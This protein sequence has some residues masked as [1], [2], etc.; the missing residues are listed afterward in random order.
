MTIGDFMLYTKENGGTVNQ[1]IFSKRAIQRLAIALVLAIS[2][3]P[4]SSSPAAAISLGDYFQISYDFEFSQTV[5]HGG[6]VFYVTATGT[7]TCIKDLEFPYNMV[8]EVSI[9]SRVVA[10]NQVSGTSEILNPSYTITIKPFPTKKGDTYTI[11]KVIPLQFPEGSESGDYNVLGEL[12]EAKAK[13]LLWIDVTSYLPSSQAMGSVT[14][15]APGGEPTIA[16]SPSSFAFTAIEGGSDPPNQTLSVRNSGGGTLDWS[17]TDDMDWLTLNPTSGSSTGEQNFI[18]LS[19][20]ISGISAGSYNAAITISAPGATNTP[21]TVP[22]RLIVSPMPPAAPSNLIATP[23]STSQI[24][25]SWVDNSNNET[26]FKIE[27]KTGVGGSYNQIA[28][29]GAN[30]T[31][32][33]DSGRNQGTT[34]CYRVRAYNAGGNSA[35]SNE[36]C[37][38]TFSPPNMPSNPLPANHATGVSINADLSWSG[39]D[40]DAGD[41]VTYDVYF[42]TSAT[43]PLVSNDQPETT[44]DPGILNYNTKYYWQIVAT[45]NHG[46]STQGT[47]W[48]FTTELAPNNPPNTPSL[49]AGP[50]S[51]YT[52]TSYTYSTSATDP[53]GDQ[54]KYTFDWGDGTTS[55]TGFVN[56]GTTA[57][58]SHSWGSPGTYNVKAKATDSKGVSSG[59]SDAKAV[60]ISA[61]P[62]KPKMYISDIQMALKSSGFWFW[63]YT[64]ATATVT[65]VDTQNNTVEGAQVSG[66]WS[67]ATNDSDSGTTDPSGKVTFASNSVGS[68]PNGTTFTFTVN[69]VTKSG[70]TYNQAANIETSDSIT[71]GGTPPPTISFSPSSFS[72]NAILGGA[73]PS[74]QT[75]RIW[76]S[77]GGT[78]NW[79]VSDDAAWLSLSPTGGSSTG[80][81]DNVT[82][83][84]S[85]SGMSTG[86]YN[87]TITISAPGITNSPQTVPVRLVISAPDTTPPVINNVAVS[88]ISASSATITWKTDEMS[89]SKVEYGKTES[90]GSSKSNTSLV[91]SHSIT[92]IG[93]EPGTSYHYKV[94]S[95]DSSGNQASSGDFIFTTFEQPQNVMHIADI[96]MALK[97]GGFW[98]LKYTYATA[99]VTVVDAQSNP[100]AGTQV[101]GHWSG[102]TNDSDSGITDPSGKVTLASDSK[103]Q[104]PMGTT[105]TFTV[106]N[107]TKNGWTYNPA[108]N[109]ETSDSITVNSPSS[110]SIF[111]S[112]LPLAKRFIQK[113]KEICN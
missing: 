4:I 30:V 58:K 70:W 105:F 59:W 44:Y 99:T 74:D 106:D 109:V 43:P 96:Q 17:V 10:E 91:T 86:S 31:T 67:G 38:T 51:G 76:N 25:L 111:A 18:T 113:V 35:Y 22:V 60:T 21:R 78:L 100:V 77:G 29:V 108:A 46:T 103:W 23:L 20:H 27:R 87:A 19:V 84:V 64:Y 92:L 1:K 65:V 36:A 110:G 6:E 107:A 53:D 12:I 24:D 56:S 39:G 15:I 80:E 8:S 47:V 81:R 3:V 26:G 66:Q 90:Y 45:D 95:S 82:V 32:Y 101:S 61:P 112:I 102:A 104:A 34:Y 9:T 40:P 50:A 16:F 49:P 14:Y 42:G 28:S 62:P 63:K 41:T 37:A 11:E 52:G 68:A 72:F 75:L 71:V 73:N 7:A 69:D 94:S 57:S 89:D 88:N 55:E 85:I 48:E 93:L 79:S 2:L 83:S 54:V 98:F 13:A 97:S 33:S 5:I